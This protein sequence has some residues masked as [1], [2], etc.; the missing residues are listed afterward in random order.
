MLFA[1]GRRAS[2]TTLLL[3]PP[4][5]FFKMYVLKL[6]FLDGFLGFYMS[7]MAALSVFMK[8]L[9]LAELSRQAARKGRRP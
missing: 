9:K 1:E 7:V 3:H 6:G 8:Y 5:T 4:F 2:V